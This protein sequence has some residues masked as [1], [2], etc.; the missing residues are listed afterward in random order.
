MVFDIEAE[1]GEL[2]QVHP[3]AR[4]LFTDA[5]RVLFILDVGP[6]GS[7]RGADG[8]SE[9]LEWREAHPNETLAA[10]LQSIVETS[11]GTYDPGAATERALEQLLNADA[12]DEPDLELDELYA[13]DE[14]IIS[15][16]L[17]HLLATGS[18][19]A[20]AR[21]T[22]DVALTRQRHP[23]ILERLFGS[24]ADLRRDA[25]AEVTALLDAATSDPANRRTRPA[26]ARSMNK[27]GGARIYPSRAHRDGASGD[28]E[29]KLAAMMNGTERPGGIWVSAVGK[30]HEAIT[31]AFAWKLREAGLELPGFDEIYFHPTT[32]LAPR[33]YEVDPSHPTSFFRSVSMGVELEGFKAVCKGEAIAEGLELFGGAVAALAEHFDLDRALVERVRADFRTHGLDFEVVVRRD[34]GDGHELRAIAGFRVDRKH[35][36]TVEHASADG[37]R[38]AIVVPAGT[39]GFCAPA[40]LE[41]VKG[42]V[43]VTPRRGEGATIKVKLKDMAVVSEP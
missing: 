9:Y 34:A 4:P 13:L 41:L 36:L 30:V 14:A 11:H 27:F 12:E 33:T 17:V 15:A 2:V 25:L 22:V 7:D 19:D 39:P 8:R 38:R 28:S 42:V 35:Q 31:E 29:A 26:A 6:L 10:Y 3:D 1:I 40:R 20:A 18:I 37:L 32:A 21:R 43:K 5:S 23:G 16:A 24:S